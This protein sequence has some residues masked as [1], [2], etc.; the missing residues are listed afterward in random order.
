MACDVFVSY[1]HRD[2]RAPNG[3][4]GFISRLIQLIKIRAEQKYGS[5]IAWFW[6]DELAS[7]TRWEP[8]SMKI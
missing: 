3:F 7:G 5:D 6:D 8:P 4:Q 1:A 2:N